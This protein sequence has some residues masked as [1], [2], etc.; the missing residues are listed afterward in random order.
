MQPPQGVPN[1]RRPKEH[2]PYGLWPSPISPALLAEDRRLE[3]ACWDSDGRSVVWLEGRSGRGVLVVQPSPD[4]APRQLAPQ[5]DVR[6]EVAY[7][8]GDF[9][10]H[11]GYVYF[12]VRNT[13]RIYRQSLAGGPAM[14]VTPGYGHAASPTVSPDG[15]WLVYVHHDA[16]GNDR[17]AIV[18]TAGRFWPQILASGHDF[19]MQPAWSPDG[20]RLAWVAWDHPHMPWEESLLYLAPVEY[21]QSALPRLGAPEVAAGGR[22]VAVQ[23]PEFSPDGRRLYY[24]SDETGW[25]RLAMLDLASRSR[26]WL[27]PEGIECGLPAW[28]QGVRTFA[29][30][31]NGQQLVAAA[32]QQGRH[33]LYRIDLEQ[34]TCRPLQGLEAY[35]EVSQVVASPT[36]PRVLVIGSGPAVPPRLVE[37]DLASGRQRVVARASAESVPAEALARC[38][39]M[40]WR[41]SDG[42]EVHGLFYAPASDR[43]ASSGK[44]PLVVLVHGGPT[45]QAR[46]AWNPQA[47]FFATRG[48]AV[49]L[50]NYRGSTGYGRQYML[51][52]RGQWGVYDVEDAVG[53][54]A[55]LAAQG[56][57]DPHRAAIMGASAGGFT[58]L[59]AMIEH[60]ETFAAGVCLYGVADP[61]HL[62]A[63]T[64]KFEARYLDFLLGPLPEAAAVYRQRS[65]VLRA[66]QIRRPLA[67]FQGDADRVVPR[68]Q[69][70]T[71]VEA[72]RRNR[73]PHVYHVYEGEGHG[74]RKRETIE[75]FYN[76]VER[77]LRQH[78]AL[79]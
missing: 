67:V 72:L 9:T 78:V 45:S 54:L 40:C 1:E 71:I 57:V 24:L 39:P 56:Y 75:H 29:V 3:G 48:Y 32:T 65:A 23:Q 50:V 59:R 2:R 62:A 15:R 51:K 5:W 30:M 13:G 46:C 66:E 19:S 79:A 6:A 18:D 55:H 22:D 47:Q 63:Q 25:S 33:C 68:Q 58:V 21:P 69:S 49:L 60:P 27:T 42:D 74:W 53:G 20:T 76:A 41:S 64:H 26:Q 37:I 17:L 52:L 34:S 4:E 70:D 16:E 7:G 36:G 35:G 77:F 12:V 31:V 61:F 43:Y 38:E 8:G 11:G 28:V 10:V 14:P 44:P 73:T